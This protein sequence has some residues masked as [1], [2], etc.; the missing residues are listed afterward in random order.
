MDARTQRTLLRLGALLLA[1]LIGVVIVEF[2][3]DD[4][5]RALGIGLTT[6]AVLSLEEWIRN[7]SDFAAPTVSAVNAALPGDSTV[8]PPKTSKKTSADAG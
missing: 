5:V 1:L 6:V 8:E 7:S 2:V 3:H 4:A